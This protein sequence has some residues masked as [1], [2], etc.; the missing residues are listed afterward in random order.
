M[1]GLELEAGYIEAMAA[2]QGLELV[3]T[4]AK[5]TL[6]PGV[7]VQPPDAPCVGNGFEP[8]PI[9]AGKGTNLVRSACRIRVKPG[10]TR[11]LR[12]QPLRL[13]NQFGGL[14]R[15]AQGEEFLLGAPHCGQTAF[16][17]EGVGLPGAVD[18]LQARGIR[19]HPLENGSVMPDDTQ[20][21]Q[22]ENPEAQGNFFADA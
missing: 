7:V 18:R 20:E 22:T 13:L 10:Q 9:V 11:S 19:E 5:R 6:Q 3:G 21:H 17:L 16:D 8:C 2:R 14:S 12:V 1:Q 4:V 15:V